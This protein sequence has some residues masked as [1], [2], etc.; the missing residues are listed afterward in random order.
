M[1]GFRSKLD[2]HFIPFTILGFIS[3]AATYFTFRFA[4]NFSL[5]LNFGISFGIFIVSAFTSQMP[6]HFLQ[7]HRKSTI[8]KAV[9]STIQFAGGFL[10]S[11]LIGIGIFFGLGW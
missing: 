8:W 6:A 11:Y 4:P 9:K 10:L 1:A 3:G 2:L 5:Y 7:G